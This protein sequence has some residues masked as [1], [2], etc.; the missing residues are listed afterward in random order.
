MTAETPEHDRIS[1][2]TNPPLP[3]HQLVF[4]PAKFHTFSLSTNI[5][6]LSHP[7]TFHAAMTDERGCRVYEKATVAQHG[8]LTCDWCF[9]V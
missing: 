2:V 9:Y 3:A 6:S 7:V 5:I 1:T 4:I 8:S